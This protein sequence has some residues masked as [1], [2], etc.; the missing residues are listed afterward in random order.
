LY[1]TIAGNKKNQGDSIMHI[2]TICFIKKGEE[3]LLLNRNFAPNMGLWNGVGGKIQRGETPE[4]CIK[5]EVYEET[6][7]ALSKVLYKGTVNWTVDDERFGGMY[8]YIAEL[9][10]SFI[11]TTPRSMQEG[12]LEWKPLKWIINNQNLG[13]VSN[14]PHFLPLALSSEDIYE[15]HCTYTQGQLVHFEAKKLVPILKGDA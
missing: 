7:I 4:Q 13:V 5:R 14:I 9:P 1:G 8:L 6:G 2:Y 11:Y 12:I 15:H 10:D 3:L